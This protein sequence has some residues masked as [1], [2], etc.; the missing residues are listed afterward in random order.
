MTTGSVQHVIFVHIPKAAGSTLVRILKNQYPPESIFSS[1]PLRQPLAKLK[2]F[3]PEKRSRIRLV[4]GHMAYGAHEHF[5]EPSVYVSMIRHPVPR[6]ISHYRFVLRRPSHY[7][8]E[9]AT[10]RK[11][12]LEE[13]V[14]SGIS[15]E[16]DN[17]Q[18]RLLAGHDR[19]IPYGH[20]EELLLEKAKRNILEHF[21]FVG[22]S[23]DFDRSLIV[24]SRKLHWADVPVYRRV[25]V[26]PSP[27]GEI[28]EGTIRAIE[29]CN[30]LDLELYEWVKAR[31]QS[32][33]EAESKQLGRI[34][35][36]FLVRN[37]LYQTTT[38][39]FHQ[40]NRL[41]RRSARRVLKV[42]GALNASSA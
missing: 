31:V 24:M 12:S 3:P 10:S 9:T 4:T 19:D 25:N 11:M 37:W 16:T 33:W 40:V 28:P 13:Y 21:A 36:R 29:R 30:A 39:H 1:H 14:R 17:G 41:A 34:H 23:E 18:V 42:V 6:L 7:L 2:G 15:T 38:H 20:C 8:Y 26:A 27:A 22:I 35:R 5:V 32:E